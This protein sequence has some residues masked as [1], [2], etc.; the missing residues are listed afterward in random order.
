MGKSCP[1]IEEA[2]C[3]LIGWSETKHIPPQPYRQLARILDV[4]GYQS[5]ASD[6]LFASRKRERAEFGAGELRWWS[7]SLL[8]FTIGYG[9]G[10]RYFTAL[11][12]MTVFTYLGMAILFLKGERLQGGAKLGDCFWYS[13]DMMLLIIRLDEKH[14]EI[15][16]PN[17][18]VKI[19]YYMHKFAG[20]VLVFFV[21]AGLTGL[22]E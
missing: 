15:L 11:A 14:Y 8:Q 13:L 18:S 7:L 16:L 4:S 22:T 12:W 3:I 10:W 2:I 9:Y 21:I 20:Y 6:I 5:M 1:T 17:R 19:Y